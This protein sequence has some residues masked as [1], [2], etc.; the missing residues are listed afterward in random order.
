MGDEKA[1]A[2]GG[3]K[4]QD[5]PP[6]TT[7]KAPAPE[8]HGGPGREQ[9]EHKK[10]KEEKKKAPDTTGTQKQQAEDT[11]GL[12]QSVGNQQT[13]RLLRAARDSAGSPGLPVSHPDDKA[14]KE[15]EAVAKKVTE[16]HPAHPRDHPAPAHGDP[17]AIHGDPHEMTGDPEQQRQ[18]VH[19]A[20]RDHPNTPAP[21]G[22][23]PP[24]A[25]AKGPDHTSP[26]AILNHPGPGAPIPQPTRSTL[27]RKLNADLRHVVVHHDAQADTAVRALHARAVTKGNHIWLASDASP[28]DL[29]LM[30]H[31]VAHVLQHHNHTV[32]RQATTGTPPPTSFPVPPATSTFGKIETAPGKQELKLAKVR[33]P[34]WRQKRMSQTAGIKNSNFTVRERGKR[35]TNQIGIWE[36]NIPLESDLKS[37]KPSSSPS[38]NIGKKL[39]PL[40]GKTAKIDQAGKP[41][42]YL[43]E[44]PGTS[45][46]L[47]GTR[48]EISKKAQRPQWNRTGGPHRLDVDHILE[49]QLGGE[50]A[51]AN[52]WLLDS[53]ANQT[54]GPALYRE[55][56]RQINGLLSE[57]KPTLGAQIPND[58]AKALTAPYRTTVLALAGGL[59]AVDPAVV[60]DPKA[61]WLSS[62]VL[63]A[64]HLEKVSKVSAQ[65]AAKLGF[66]NVDDPNQL[67][68]MTNPSGG[69]VVRVP[70][71]DAKH[72]PAANADLTK[73]TLFPFF[74]LSQV[75]YQNGKGTLTG[76]VRFKRDWLSPANL[77]LTLE[78]HPRLGEHTAVVYSKSVSPKGKTSTQAGDTGIE[79]KTRSLRFR[80]LSE[81]TITE[82]DLR[83]GVGL[84]LR[85]ALTPS[86]PLLRGKTIDIEASGQDVSLSYTWLAKDLEAPKPIKL[87]DGSFTVGLG[88]QGIKGSGSVKVELAPIAK[89]SLEASFSSDGA[90]GI[91]GTLDFDTKLFKPA[92]ASF[93]YQKQQGGNYE[94]G[95]K[96]NLGIGPQQVPGIKSAHIAVSYENKKF[97]ASGDAQL[98]IP[99]LESGKLDISYAEQEGVSIGGAF[100]LSKDVPGIQSGEVSATVARKP[101][102]NQ[103]QLSA[104][105]TAKPKVPGVDATL[106]ASYE[107]GVFTIEGQAAYARGMLSGSIQVGVTNRPINPQGQ[108]GGKPAPN[109]PLRLYGGGQLTLK[110]AP[111]LQATAGVKLEQ[112]G[113]VSLTG[114]VGLPDAINLFGAKEI[115][116]NIVTIGLDIPIVGISVLGQRI[117]IFATI[118]GGLEAEAGV[119]PGQ[120]RQLGLEVQYNPAH[121]DQ[122]SITGTAQLHIPAHAGLRLFVRGA[123]GAGIPL[124]SAEAGLEVGGKLGVEGAV[125]ASVQVNWTPKK[126][127]V[128]DAVAALSAEPKFT[129]D[130]NGYVKVEVDT[131]LFSATLYEKHWQL[132]S[133]EYGSGL[134]IGVRA[135]VHYEQGK[136]FDFN[137]SD[138]Q[139]ELPKVDPGQILKDL[140]KRIA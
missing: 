3:E 46:V 79:Q 69:S 81:V 85:G 87:T 13:N 10:K 122:T 44:F 47:L 74:R 8:Q 121:E 52:F 82:F 125:Q 86:I 5:T 129:F 48:E 95:I 24:H 71:D 102:G 103:W 12:Q 93:S 2:Q 66:S 80:G 133:F 113:S 72:Q 119:G 29:Q 28:N 7:V 17:T 114:K 22:P 57:A 108:P 9:D 25:P 63:D 128:I 59:E 39:E 110:L 139:F 75:A 55:I 60:G 131:F 33:V 45:G 111:W 78:R 58:P 36:K 40:F 83:E 61:Y 11:A 54:S 90:F 15:A 37:D 16:E 106:Q 42:L 14:E 23:T 136:P 76:E 77:D 65:Q 73:L 6:P 126:G 107:D 18:T 43:L 21:H 62:E 1:Q 104:H 137:L 35:D 26:T 70:W 51:F 84:Y 99:G 27:E 109:A 135:P 20:V 34:T 132:A 38:T 105:G 68:I 118:Q 130:I 88:T 53:A 4:K 112:D 50:D 19:R 67:V 123:L 120:L 124:V 116:K 98:S 115:K 89:G 127:L 101:P 31:E 30:A 32:H 100:Q 49:Y 94:W 41:T 64:K 56:D 97:A 91:T 96:G 134:R 92:Q 140:V 117:G 138:V